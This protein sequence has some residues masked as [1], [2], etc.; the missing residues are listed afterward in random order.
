MLT[1]LIAGYQ[2][3]ASSEIYGYQP[4]RLGN[5]YVDIYQMTAALPKHAGYK[6][7]LDKVSNSA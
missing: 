6:D 4:F 2:F 7:E 5:D 3:S 1:D